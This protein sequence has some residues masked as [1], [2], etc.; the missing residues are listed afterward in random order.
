MFMRALTNE[1]MI[2]LAREIG[3][4]LQKHYGKR[5]Y[6]SKAMIDGAARRQSLDQNSVWWAYTIFTSASQFE[7]IQRTKTEKLDY[8][9]MRAQFLT[10]IMSDSMVVN[11]NAW[12]DYAAI[13]LPSFLE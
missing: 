1:E 3:Q 11:S 4:D 2:N 5:K 8:E 13:V 12:L 9:A 6:Y 10:T 7:E